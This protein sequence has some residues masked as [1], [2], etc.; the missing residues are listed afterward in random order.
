LDTINCDLDHFDEIILDVSDGNTDKIGILNKEDTLALLHYVKNNESLLIKLME[1]I[2]SNC[3]DTNDWLQFP[4]SNTLN[5]HI[6]HTLK[7]INPPDYKLLSQV[8]QKCFR[9]GYD[10]VTEYVIQQKYIRL[11]HKIP[12]W[13]TIIEILKDESLYSLYR[14]LSQE[15]IPFLI[16]NQILKYSDFNIDNVG[17]LTNLMPNNYSI[18]EK[19]SW[20]HSLIVSL[21]KNPLDFWVI[22]DKMIS[23]SEDKWVKK[24][25]PD[26]GY[27]YKTVLLD[28]LCFDF[29]ISI[30]N[31]I[32]HGLE[33]NI[34][35]C[36]KF[37]EYDE[38]NKLS[39]K[40]KTTLSDLTK[41]YIDEVSF[42]NYCS[43]VSI[44]IYKPVC[45]YLL[46]KK[47]ITNFGNFDYLPIEYINI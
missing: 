45:D 33:D 16:E 12:N 29:Y 11:L 4:K 26:N 32:R 21:I 6:A 24:N 17:I 31:N 14:Q 20:L 25:H 10:S 35:P 1:K 15:T 8:E 5:T 2:P 39:K 46:A 13:N 36:N 41:V 7:T 37:F 22:Y 18:L 19:N 30:L 3:L 47:K 44:G 9:W 40:G 34:K 43:R 38:F 42:E 23:I 28:E 27:V